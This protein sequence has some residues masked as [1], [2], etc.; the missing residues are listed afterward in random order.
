MRTTVGR[1]LAVAVTLMALAGC[2]HGS[3][4]HPSTT[5]AAPAISLGAS[6]AVRTRVIGGTPAMRARARAILG[7][8][9]EV[10]IAEVRFGRPPRAFARLRR[11]DA[12]MWLSTTVV[13]EGSPFTGS[14]R[15][16]L[17]ADG[18]LWQAT[19]FANA[20][21]ASQPAGQPR[22]G[23]TSE[24]LISAGRRSPFSSETGPA[25]PYGGAPETDAAVR[26]AII[27][28]SARAG[29]RIVSISI[30]HPNRQA[31]TVVVRATTRE[32]F[33]RRYQA[34]VSGLSRLGTRLDGL[35]WQVIDRCGYP[36]AIESVGGWASPR[37]L[38]PNP[39]VP[40]L[41]MTK[42][43]CR[44]LPRGFPPCGR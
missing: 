41:S 29:F 37:W 25:D 23:G 34:F 3:G 15:S 27:R 6:T 42:A 5:D 44:K 36:V 7:R 43:T 35:Q 31:A 9:G 40:G 8:M 1:G 11:T 2:G 18:P 12:S 4:R 28:A 17:A 26:R 38:C 24:A 30:V 16:Q 10:A 19:A 22:V 13:S 21:Q 39:Y 14:L 33:A 32:G 20:Y